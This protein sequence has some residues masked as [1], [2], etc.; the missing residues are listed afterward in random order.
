MV[1]RGSL[2]GDDCRPMLMSAEDSLD[3][4][5]PWDLSIAGMVMAARAHVPVARG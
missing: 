3:I 4:D 1:E 5:T 2:Y